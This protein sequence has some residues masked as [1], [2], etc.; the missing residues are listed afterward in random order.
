[1][2]V[3]NLNKLILSTKQLVVLYVED[4]DDVAQNMILILDDLFDKVI[5]AKNGIDGLNKF[6]ENHIDLIISD[7]NM[8]KLNGI[9]M[10]EKINKLA[11]NT[12]SILVTAESE[13]KYYKDAIDLHIKAFLN[14]PVDLYQF[15]KALEDIV[16]DIREKE[17]QSD[18]ITYLLNTNTKLLDL[19][20]QISTQKDI[21]KL[22]ENVLKGAIELSSSDGGT[23]Y[24]LN[25]KKN[26]LE[27]SISI[28]NTLDIHY[29][30][31][32]QKDSW[33]PLPLYNEDNTLNKKN[34]SVVS[35]ME[36]KLININNIYQTTSYNFSGAKEFDKKMGYKTT[37]ML[38]IPL[39]NRDDIVIGV[40]QLIN[41][42]KDNDITS[43]LSHDEHIITSMASLAT[44]VLENN[45]LVN[46][47]EHFLYSLIESIGSAIS[48]KSKYTAKHIDNV[49]ILSKIIADGINDNNT[50]YKDIKYDAVQLEEIRLA[51]LLHDIGKIS[52]PAYIMDKA[53]KLEKVCDRIDTI[54]LR[55]ELLKKDIEIAYLKNEIVE[56]KKNDIIKQLDVDLDFL[57]II[58]S[59]QTVMSDK[60][61]DRLNS[62]Y[63]KTGL[64]T[65]DEFYNLSIKAG[66]LTQ[67]DRD[68][69]N[70]HVVV[71]YDMI[72]DLQFPKKFPNVVKIASSHHKTLDGKGYAA[73]EIIDLELT[74]EDKIL[75]L[76]DIFEA[77]STQ[78]R[79]YKKPNT[80]NQI[81]YIFVSMIENKQLDKDLVKMFFED[82]LYL[83]YGKIY[84][85]DSQLDKLTVDFSKL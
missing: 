23:L 71:T 75:V 38:V 32:G 3:E 27:F 78:D 31:T 60:Y 14:K 22:L 30:G 35:A 24:L 10:L 57:N 80:I 55:F 37:S 79:P 77:L 74:L 50:I 56:H 85:H 81:A 47:L 43:F 42:H 2:D 39:K 33:P 29:G 13:T 53:T 51:A 70:N 12:P 66:T 16:K 84:L 52:T 34:V 7:I 63:E 61:I 28:N 76:A 11:P 62:I 72:K 6:N 73:K 19:A 83:K 18:Q 68:I 59:G 45:Q 44:M 1:M 48:A 17:I 20:S 82:K 69:I 21:N 4:N 9:E 26:I 25:K 67:K 46:D 58:N 36:D 65:E 64:L 5:Y 8:P 41:K 54:N 15:Y 40:I 49:S